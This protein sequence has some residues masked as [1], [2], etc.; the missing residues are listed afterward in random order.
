MDHVVA[1]GLEVAP[2]AVGPGVG[3]PAGELQRPVVRLPLVWLVGLVEPVRV[4][5]GA[6]VSGVEVGWEVSPVFASNPEVD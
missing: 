3:V 4:S 6:S 5:V 2:P 1:E